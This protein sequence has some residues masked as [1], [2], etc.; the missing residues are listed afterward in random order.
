MNIHANPACDQGFDFRF[1]ANLS[2]VDNFD[3][4]KNSFINLLYLTA[5]LRT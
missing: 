3:D 1:E 5:I 4:R 2:P